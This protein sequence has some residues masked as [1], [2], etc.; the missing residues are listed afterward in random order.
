MGPRGRVVGVDL[1]AVDPPLKNENVVSFVGELEDSHLC[2]QIRVE[3]R[4]SCHVLLSDAAPKLTGVR[5]ADRAA[6]ERILEAVERMIP[7]ILQ[8]DG[9]LLVKLLECPEAQN[10]QRRIRACFTRAKT[11][12]AEATRK[13][14]S[15]RYLLARG[16]RPT[17]ADA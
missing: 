2:E 15:E 11:V 1:V 13:G 16:Y 8:Q 7:L 5:E 3:L 9:D 12:R 17:A 10:F 6:E 4:G 14:S